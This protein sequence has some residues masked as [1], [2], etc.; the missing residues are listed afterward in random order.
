M[1]AR[2]RYLTHLRTTTAYFDAKNNVRSF[3]D[4]V[5]VVGTPLKKALTEG[6]TLLRR[7]MYHSTMFENAGI[8]EKAGGM[9]TMRKNWIGP[10]APSVSGPARTFCML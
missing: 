2:W 6:K 3:L 8:W 7:A 10:C 1:W 5:P 4:S 9:V